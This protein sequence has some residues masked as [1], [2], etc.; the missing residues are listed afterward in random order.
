MFKN[1]SK[2]CPYLK[3]SKAFFQFDKNKRLYTIIAHTII[4]G[5]D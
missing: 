2:V 1:F 5:G 3:V 4:E